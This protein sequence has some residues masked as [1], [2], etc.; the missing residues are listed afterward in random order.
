MQGQKINIIVV[1]NSFQRSKQL[2]ERAIMSALQQKPLPYKVI[3]IDQNTPNINLSQSMTENPIF[4][5]VPSP[6]ICVSVARNSLI[7]PANT[8]W[9]I[10]CDD[11]GFLKEDYL[12]N[13]QN[14]ISSNQHLD[15]IAGSI[16]RDD[17]GDFYSPRHAFG[18]NLNKF[19]HTKLLM[20]SN[21][22]LKAK[23][24]QELEGFDEQ[25]GAGSYWGSGEETDFAWKAHFAGKQMAYHPE[26]VVFHIKPYAGTF[27]HSVKKAFHYG[28]GKGALVTKWL[29]EKR[30]IKVTL[31]LIEMISIP[32]AQS[33]LNL[34][35]LK[36]K[37]SFINMVT[38]VARVYGMFKYL[39]QG[40]SKGKSNSEKQ[41]S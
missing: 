20:G 15:I 21:F 10:F 33:V 9:I 41:A 26:L 1:I 16:K 12:L 27:S 31:E 22:A 2:V 23:V 38:L 6:A 30:K 32:I 17:N 11:D 35:K 4:Q 8:D 3:F 5:Q 25:F 18:G 36:F 24:F 40:L 39:L 13:L 37:L 19:F 34:L 28:Q 14:I 29:I 7:M